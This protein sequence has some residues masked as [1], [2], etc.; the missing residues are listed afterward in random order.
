MR[1]VLPRAPI[2]LYGEIKMRRKQAILLGILTELRWEKDDP[3][4][5]SHQ[6]RDKEININIFCYLEV[7]VIKTFFTA[8]PHTISVSNKQS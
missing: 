2:L 6:Q 5:A 4:S 7:K 8:F 3:Q 1:A